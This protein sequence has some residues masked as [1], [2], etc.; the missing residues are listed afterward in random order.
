VGAIDDK[1][2]LGL[3][4]RDM[5]H[6]SYGPSV[7]GLQKPE[8]LAPG[9]WLAAPILP[10]TPTAAQARLLSALAAADDEHLASIVRASPGVDPEL[11]AAAPLAAPLLRQLVAVKVRDTQVISGSY[12]HVDGTSFAAPIVS[13][14]AAQMLEAN[15]RLR[16]AELKRILMTT[17][18]RL[19][20]VEVERQGWGVVDPRAAVMEAERLG[21]EAPARRAG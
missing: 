4:G 9:I 19:P 2:R 18:R 16:P 10:G 3:E 17:A 7:D 13:A 20:H 5:Y 1:N 14:I 15:P 6:S 8:V 21:Q 12:K 11:D